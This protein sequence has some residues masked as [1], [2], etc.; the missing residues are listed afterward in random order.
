M[1]PSQQHAEVASTPSSDRDS[2]SAGLPLV[3]TSP[4]SESPP[5][6]TNEFLTTTTR[7][8]SPPLLAPLAIPSDAPAFNLIQPTP[9]TARPKD[10]QKGAGT[11][12][13]E[14]ILGMGQWPTK[15]VSPSATP[16]QHPFAPS[17]EASE[18]NPDSP[19]PLPLFSS[20]LLLSQ[21]LIL[22]LN[23]VT[24]TSKLLPL[25]PSQRPQRRPLPSPTL[26]LI[27]LPAPLRRLPP[28][29]LSQTQ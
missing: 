6:S 5:P 4:L 10:R 25:T 29:T 26:L 16:L 2:S 21:A 18:L 23:R 15:E 20:D 3:F 17:A 7:T 12:E 13:L 19:R 28:P 9:H 14:S 8:T 22:N 1:S 24:A 11:L 27:R